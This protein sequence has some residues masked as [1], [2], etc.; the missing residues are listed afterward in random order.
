MILHI[1]ISQLKP[2]LLVFLVL[3]FVLKAA[4]GRFVKVVLLLF[5]QQV[6]YFVAGIVAPGA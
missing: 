6:G 4:I 5:V 2:D 1:R 3:I